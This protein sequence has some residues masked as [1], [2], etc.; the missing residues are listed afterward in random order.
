MITSTTAKS[1]E[2]R[3]ND[4]STIGIPIDMTDE[5]EDFG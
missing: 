4:T 1:V 2:I 5:L 3:K